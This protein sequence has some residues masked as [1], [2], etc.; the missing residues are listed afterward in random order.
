[1]NC[2]VLGLGRVGWHHAE[3]IATKIPG[4]RLAA[5]VDPD[6]ERL[7]KFAAKYGTPGI[8]RFEDVMDDPLIDAVVIASPTPT[9]IALASAAAAAGKGIFCEKP[10]SLR[11]GDYDQLIET[12]NRSRVYMQVGY[13]RRFDPGYQMAKSIIEA[14]GIGEVIAFNGITRDNGAPPPDF[15][16]QSGGMYLD[17]LIH[18]FD[19]ARFLGGQPITRVYARGKDVM[20]GTFRP[21]DDADH[22]YVIVDFANG[23]LGQVEGSRCAVYGHDVRAE[24]IGTR[25]T[26]QVGY[27][28]QTPVLHLIPHQVQHDTLPG[29][30]E[31]FGNAYEEELREFIQRVQTEAPSPVTLEE[32]RPA[33]LAALA[34]T[35]SHQTDKPVTLASLES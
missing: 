22:A 17:V 16:A 35:K 7:A 1:M 15:I 28:Q 10:V 25:G 34:A 24:I 31:R 2:A 30:I 14:G 29:F 23:A 4:A 13:M 27:L 20:Y 26:L 8:Q 3:T 6:T 12:I 5:V 11:L 32:A 21:Y 9:H 33:L 18:E 19:I